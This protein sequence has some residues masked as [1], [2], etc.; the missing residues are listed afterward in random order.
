MRRRR[1]SILTLGIV[2]AVVA[3]DCTW[4][5]TTYLGTESTFRMDAPAFDMGVLP[6]AHVLAGALLFGRRRGAFFR[7]FMGGGVLA[8]LA[9]MGMGWFAPD[10]VRD[11]LRPIYVFRDRVWPAGWNYDLYAAD[12]V[13]FTPQQ[14]LFA[15]VCGLIAARLAGGGRPREGPPS[16]SAEGSP[17]EESARPS[18]S[19]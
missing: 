1:S 16:G 17:S 11:W 7:G 12:A 14:V 18:R 4:V 5:R 10:S 13:Y 8:I 19:P 15:L 2:A 9:L 6:M 3:L